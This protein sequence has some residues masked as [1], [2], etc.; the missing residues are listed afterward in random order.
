MF[1]NLVFH[2]S[3]LVK[4][5]YEYFISFKV[6]YSQ[7]SQTYAG[8]WCFQCWPIL[9]TVHCSLRSLTGLLLVHLLFKKRPCWRLEALIKQTSLRIWPRREENYRRRRVKTVNT[10][11]LHKFDLF[12][13][14]SLWNVWNVIQWLK[15]E[16]SC[17]G[18]AA[19]EQE[20]LRR[21]IHKHNNNNNNKEELLVNAAPVQL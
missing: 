12:A 5:K 6:V 13:T 1:Q 15:W 11:S 17:W 2:V 10:D 14:K 7:I 3:V 9:M 16:L 20:L 4:N 18:G 8:S 21:F 19:W